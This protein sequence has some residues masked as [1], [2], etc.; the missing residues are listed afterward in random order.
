MMI[1]EMTQVKDQSHQGGSVRMATLFLTTDCNLHC[2][3]CYALENDFAAGQE[4]DTHR[5]G[6]LLDLL[7]ERGYR[8]S[9]G[10]GEP[11]THP[12]LA[13]EAARMAAAR[14]MGVSLLTNGYLLTPRL[15]E[16]LHEAGVAWIQISADSA[17]EVRHFVPFLSAGA[18]LGLRMAIGTVLD[19][20][21]VGEVGAMHTLLAENGATGWRI[22]RFT[23]LQDRPSQLE[24]P[25][26]RQWVQTLLAVERT[27]RPIAGAVQIRYEPSIVPMDWLLAQPK[28]ERLD[29]CGGRSSRRLFLYPDGG[30]FACGL[31]RRKGIALGNW[32]ENFEAFARHLDAPPVVDY[33]PEDLAGFELDYCREVCR[34]GCVQMRG[35]LACDPRCELE[36]GFVPVCCFEKLLL[37]SGPSGLGKP[38]YPSELFG[39]QGE[40]LL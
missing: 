21:Q 10:G 6:P 33:L 18:K 16:E 15:L 26:N 24:P 34:G 29:V 28:G 39:E 25:S 32:M 20:G 3:Y 17:S 27:L 23:P 8:I 22:L 38:V 7:A 1:P 4:W 12:E 13:L 14:G 5:I 19:P 37:V 9:L 35:D 30:G 40:R 31:P 2:P 36:A 11:L